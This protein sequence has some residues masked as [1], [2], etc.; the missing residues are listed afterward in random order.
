VK[1]AGY[2]I[3]IGGALR[4]CHNLLRPGGRLAFT[5]AVWRVE[6]PPEEYGEEAWF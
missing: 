3:E 1:Y 6:D 2:N 4:I 5:N